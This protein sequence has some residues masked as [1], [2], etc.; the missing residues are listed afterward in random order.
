MVVVAR[1]AR[2]EHTELFVAPVT[3][4]PPGSD[5][6]VE[7]PAPVKRHLGLDDERSWVI[8]TELNRFIWPGPDVRLAPGSGDPFYGAIPA[9]LFE[10]VRSAIVGTPEQIRMTK[11]TE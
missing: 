5:E 2:G 10:R 6:G 11:R 1:V 4:S 8:T 3:H 9:R 7:L